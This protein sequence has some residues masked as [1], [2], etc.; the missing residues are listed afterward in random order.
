MTEFIPARR[1]LVRL[2]LLGAALGLCTLGGGGRIAMRVIALQTE[3][4]SAM[5]VDGTITVLLAGAASG[6][7]GVVLLLISRA[8]RILL[9][10]GSAWLQHLLFAALL[11]WITLR[12]LHPV[13]PFAASLFLPL[14]LLYAA[15]LTRWAGGDLPPA[16]EVTGAASFSV[17]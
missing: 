17:G 12:G 3:A 6:V 14:V 5:S 16:R 15:L 2:L 4:P 9:R 7:G 10:P 11:L 1:S 13:Q 8:A